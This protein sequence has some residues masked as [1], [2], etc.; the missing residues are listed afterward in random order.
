MAAA[1]VQG[2]ECPGPHSIGL[3]RGFGH[4]GR[5]EALALRQRLARRGL[6]AREVPIT[7]AV[8]LWA[9]GPRGSTPKRPCVLVDVARDG[10]G[11][12]AERAAALAEAP[13]VTRS[14]AHGVASPG[15]VA[16]TELLPALQVHRR[17]Q[18]LMR[19]V[20][21]PSAAGH[22]SD[23]ALRDVRVQP[24]QPETGEVRL[25]LMDG[26][27]LTL[28]PGAEVTMVPRSDAVQVEV[29]ETQGEPRTW[30]ARRV[31]LEQIAGQHVVHRDGLRVADLTALTVERLPHMVVRH[32]V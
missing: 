12:E 23:I 25:R 1:A 30:F 8:T 9:D 5:A 21:F 14:R 16:R 29:I 27:P 26:L 32:A 10:S 4:A 17:P 11:R 22:I 13:V 15:R 3:L 24:N 28:Q 6:V 2:C 7:V 19:Q 31:V 18:G 20:T